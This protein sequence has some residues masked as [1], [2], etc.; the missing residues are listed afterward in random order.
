MHFFIKSPK[1]WITYLENSQK[2]E[3]TEIGE[4]VKERLQFL[5]ISQET[6]DDVKEAYPILLPLKKEIVQQF[7]QYV[8]SV[9]SFKHIIIQHSTLDRLKTTMEK[10]T[11]QLL[12][13]NVNK[14]YVMSRIA[15]GQ[16]NSRIH[17]TAEHFIAAHQLLTQIMTTV[18][19]E[20]LH[21]RPNK[22]MK[23]IL[24]VQKLT[25]FDQQLIVEVYMEE[26]FKAFL[27]GISGMLSDMTKLDTTKQL[28]IEM[29]HLI[30][31]SHNV[32]SATEEV[33]AS[34]MEVAHHSVKVAENTEEA[35]H[36][37][38]QSKYII[39]KTLE[40]IQQVGKVY[41][42]VTWQ[43]DQLN[44]EIHQTQSVV[45]VIREI[46]DQTNLLALNASIEAA[47]AGDQG[48][49]FEV[50][51]KEVRKLAEHTKEQTI[52]IT[53][54]IESLQTVSQLLTK[55]MSSTE[56]LID[57]CVIEAQDADEALRNIVSKMQEIHQSTSEIA[58]MTE[59]Q[60]SAVVEISQRNSDILDLGTRSQQISKE[61]AQ[62]IF[63]LSK[64]MDAYRLSF[65]ETNIKLTAKDII[66]VA[67]TDHFLWKWKIYNMLLNLEEIDSKQ[68]TSYKSCRLGTWYYSDLHPSIKKKTAFQQL[69]E[70]HQAVHHYAKLAVEHYE[71]GNNDEAQS[72]FEELQKASEHVMD[73]LSQLEKE[74]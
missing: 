7:L 55:Q 50:V 73:L 29:D 33:S 74:I 42:D 49:G 16:M 70:P 65:F 30:E 45:E 13:A 37:A 59:E 58:T 11:E 32:T 36:S 5:H 63:K 67:K 23:T 34:I 3:V 14:D 27:F 28:I 25:T 53:R 54:N 43:V 62:I 12:Q 2:K 52:Q 44:Q 39:N 46:T 4:R 48:R 38:E 26:T 60:T 61:T 1:P 8:T 71:Q 72:A 68:V 22:M 35:A 9:E 66:K 17:L 10:Y 19:M 41:K 24:A 21:H 18:L 69:E 6:L 56:E 40:D 31:G 57:H 47:R 20:K 15:I 51:A 64:Q